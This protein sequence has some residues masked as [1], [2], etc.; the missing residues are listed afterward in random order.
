MSAYPASIAGRLTYALSLR[1]WSQRRLAREAST[2]DVV[3]S[4]SIINKLINGQGASQYLPELAAALGV[5][6]E[7][8][9]RGQEPMQLDELT[10]SDMTA[11]PLSDSVARSKFRAADVMLFRWIDPRC[12]AGPRCHEAD[13]ERFEPVEVPRRVLERQ[14][15]DETSLVG[16]LMPDDSLAPA[17]ARGEEMAICVTQTD[18]GRYRS[19][20]VYAL[21][22]GPESLSY[23]RIARMPSGMLRV[24]A[25]SADKN[26]YPDELVSPSDIDIVG[27]VVWSGGDR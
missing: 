6:I 11:K 23:R 18:P 5:R 17:Y 16:E 9:A 1:G 4:P 8:L 10:C 20:S 24:Y 7:W 21:R 13:A 22:A 15:L 19:G 2:Q 27:R 14:G 26:A 25:D 12:K 3:V